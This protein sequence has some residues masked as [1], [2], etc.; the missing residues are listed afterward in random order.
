M[1]GIGTALFMG[2]AL[3]LSASIADAAD[4]RVLSV[5]SVQIAAKA[6][7]ADFTTATGQPVALTIVAPSE[8]GRKL[9]G[10][11]YDMVICSV[12]AMEAM[13]KAG[14]LRPGSRSP[15]SRVGIGVMVRE[16][17]PLPDVSTPEAF[18]KTLLAARSIV[19]GDPATPNQSGVVTMKILANAGVLEAIKGKARA[20]N[21][22]DGFAMVAKG[23][24]ELALFN[25]VELPPGVRLV[26]PVPAAMQEYTSYETAV[27]AKGAAPDAAQAF[28]K[29]MTSAPARKTWEASSLEAYPYR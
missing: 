19:H 24:V 28:I 17:A 26:G 20:A 23:E 18:K 14:A 27:L 15:L 3:V 16:G 8:I 9:A 10:A 22:A 13:D 6:L 29:L 1:R 21:L 12:P 7:A 25:L 4:L 5:G 2:F 11:T